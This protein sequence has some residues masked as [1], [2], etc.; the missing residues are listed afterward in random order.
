MFFTKFS[1]LLFINNYA[2]TPCFFCIFGRF[3]SYFYAISVSVD[4]W[5]ILV[6][7]FLFSVQISLPTKTVITYKPPETAYL[8]VLDLL[9]AFLV[10]TSKRAYKLYGIKTNSQTSVNK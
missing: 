9:Y 8:R 7:M 5:S 10:K 1:T 3:F 2:L 6:K 4:F